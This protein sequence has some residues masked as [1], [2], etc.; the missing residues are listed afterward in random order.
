[1]DDLGHDQHDPDRETADDQS[2]IVRGLH[3]LHR[4]SRRRRCNR[5]AQTAATQL[6]ICLASF[7]VR[8]ADQ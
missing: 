5:L 1:M 3:V 7:A 6:T 2:P 4:L 8:K